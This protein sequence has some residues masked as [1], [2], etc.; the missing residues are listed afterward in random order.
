MN[1]GGKVGFTADVVKVDLSGGMSARTAVNDAE[2]N[3]R[4]TIVEATTRSTNNVR[5][6]RTLKVCDSRE[7]GHEERVTCRLRNANQCHTLTI[8]FFE[9]LANY[10]VR[11]E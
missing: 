1:T 11:S 4:N 7:S 5:T 2:K 9:V 8:P 3:T 6:R 10:C